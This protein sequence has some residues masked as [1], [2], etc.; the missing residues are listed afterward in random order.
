MQPVNRAANQTSGDLGDK[1]KSS[2]PNGLR[3]KVTS[4]SCSN[5]YNEQKAMSL[6]LKAVDHKAKRKF[7]N[8]FLPPN[9]VVLPFLHIV[10]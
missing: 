10:P 6:Q 8:T 5:P 1:W 7:P 3:G 9:F 2:R 4:S